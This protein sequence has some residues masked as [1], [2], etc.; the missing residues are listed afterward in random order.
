MSRWI[1]TLLTL[2]IA[3]SHIPFTAGCGHK[4]RDKDV[5]VKIDNTDQG[6]TVKVKKK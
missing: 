2:C 1:C 3:V 4:K 6:Q 5:D